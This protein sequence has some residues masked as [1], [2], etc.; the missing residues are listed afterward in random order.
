MTVMSSRSGP[1]SAAITWLVVAVIDW[2]CG[3]PGNP[4]AAPNPDPESSLELSSSDVYLKLKQEYEQ[5]KNEIVVL[6]FC[7][8]TNI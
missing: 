1:R 7:S 2:L 6:H 5:I 3:L 4:G 8:E